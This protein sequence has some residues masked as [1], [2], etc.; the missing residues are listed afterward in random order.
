M[1]KQ[2][3]TAEIN[4]GHQ[5]PDI[6]INCKHQ[7]EIITSTTAVLE[8]G[9]IAKRDI[10]FFDDWTCGETLAFYVISEVHF[11]EIRV[12]LAV[13]NESTLRDNASNVCIFKECRHIVDACVWHPTETENVL[14]VCVPPILLFM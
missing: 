11:V 12:L 3:E 4:G 7:P 9:L 8:C 14:R 10:I 2:S 5:R 1:M 6:G 13:D